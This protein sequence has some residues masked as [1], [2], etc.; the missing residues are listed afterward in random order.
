M[1]KLFSISFA[2]L[3]LLS[4][5]HFSVATH[6]CGGKVAAI[7]YSFTGEIASCGMESDKSGCPSE[8]TI[9]S[10][11]C[12]NKIAI[13]TVDSNYSPSTFSIEEITQKVL[14]TSYIPVNYTFNS[15]FLT[16]SLYT[17]VGPPNRL[18]ASEVSLSDICVFRI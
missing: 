12:H 4:G 5:M 9:A 16:S 11:C 2:C 10:N 15:Y 18:L 17:D 8:N 3:I 7:K 14:H 1:K 13:Y 6:I